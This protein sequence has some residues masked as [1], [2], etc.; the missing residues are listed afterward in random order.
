MDDFF[1][2]LWCLGDVLYY[3]VSLFMQL[4]RKIVFQYNGNLALFLSLC[5]CLFPAG[6]YRS[7]Q[8]HQ[9][10][11]RREV[12]ALQQQH[13]DPGALYD[14]SLDE[15]LDM[16][17]DEET[18]E[19]M[20]GQDLASDTDILGMWIPEVLDWPTWVCFYATA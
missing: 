4:C 12:S 19:A 17:L 16:D 2:D 20:F 1:T 7:V 15:E 6:L 10:Q 11:S 14:F 8:A 5:L 3:R 18:M 9:S 13:Q